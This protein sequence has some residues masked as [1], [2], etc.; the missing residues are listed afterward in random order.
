MVELGSDMANV[1]F[2]H[3]NG[4]IGFRHGECDFWY[5]ANVIFVT[6]MAKFGF[7]VCVLMGFPKERGKCIRPI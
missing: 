5:M 6:E 7:A 3:Q 1:T 4:R 2:G